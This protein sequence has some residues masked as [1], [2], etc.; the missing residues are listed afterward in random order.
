MPRVYDEVGLLKTNVMG[1]GESETGGKA[2]IELLGTI[3][4]NWHK[5]PTGFVYAQD[6]AKIT[7]GMLRKIEE[8][9]ILTTIVRI[10]NT[11]DRKS[12]IFARIFTPLR[13][14]GT[15]IDTI[16]EILSSKALQNPKTCRSAVKALKKSYK[17]AL[18]NID[19]ARD[20]LYKANI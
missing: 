20:I 8:S 5:D 11:F 12:E 14:A 18:K 16:R 2:H 9:S 4:E 10:L 3:A 15:D 13:D 1:V 6:M 7:Q 17:S 19:Y